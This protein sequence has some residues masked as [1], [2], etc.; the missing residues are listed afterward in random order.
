MTDLKSRIIINP[1]FSETVTVG[2]KL[3]AHEFVEG[4]KI[5]K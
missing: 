1:I 5:A 2:C 4:H 3:I